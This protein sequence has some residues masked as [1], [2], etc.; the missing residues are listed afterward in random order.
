MTWT[1]LDF[2][3]LRKHFVFASLFTLPYV[4][5]SYF[6]GGCRPYPALRPSRWVHCASPL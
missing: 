6:R 4:A 5:L 3:Y 1:F 2:Y